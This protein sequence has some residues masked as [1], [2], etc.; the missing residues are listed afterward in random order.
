MTRAALLT[1][2]AL[3]TATV[4]ALACAPTSPVYRCDRCVVTETVPPPSTAAPETVAPATLQL[5]GRLW[6]ETQMEGTG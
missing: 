6:A 2:L 4:L 5:I 1:V 3:V